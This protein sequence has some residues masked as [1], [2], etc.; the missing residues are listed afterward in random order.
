VSKRYRPAIPDRVKL[1]AALRFIG[2]TTADVEFDHCP[3]LGLREYDEE[4]RTYTPPANEPEKIVM[5]LKQDHRDKT[6][7]PRG[8]HTVIGSDRHLIDKTKPEVIEKFQVVKPGPLPPALKLPDL[9]A[10]GDKCRRCGEFADACTC[11]PV[12]QRSS[13]QRRFG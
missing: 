3:A 6:N 2:L 13:F 4:T 11:A 8:P 12:Q 7:H 5:R 1:I 9:I 10:A